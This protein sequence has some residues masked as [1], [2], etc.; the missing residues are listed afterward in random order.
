MDFQSFQHSHSAQLAN[1]PRI[2]WRALYEKLQYE[3]VKLAFP[4]YFVFNLK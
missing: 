4:N 3:V 2:Y 1:V